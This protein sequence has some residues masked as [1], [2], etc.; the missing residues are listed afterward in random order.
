MTSPTSKIKGLAFIEVLKWYS[1]TYGQRQLMDAVN[2]LPPG[3]ASYA[4]APDQPNLGLLA[5]SWYP[6]EFVDKI[7]AHLYRDMS[8]QEVDQLAADFS[9]ASVGNTLSGFYAS[10]MRKLLSPEL[11]AA[12]YQ[13]IWRLY[14]NT[15]QCEVIVHAPN[16]H[17]V[18]VFSWSGHTPFL[19]KMV[20]H[21]TRN[22]LEVIG[23]KNVTSRLIK[24]VGHK[25]PYC[26]YELIWT[27]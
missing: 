26:A 16:K 21:A 24:C 17:E 25:D 11:I 18:R 3:L 15:G 2:A 6:A 14:L 19:C 1:K 10:F 8:A 4:T 12:H 13:K 22:V 7:F 5:G 20:Q 27:P 9:Q 23:C